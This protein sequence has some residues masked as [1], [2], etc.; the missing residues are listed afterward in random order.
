M[1]IFLD[2][3]DRHAYLRLLG[4]I[5]LRMDWHCL[6]YCLMSNHV[7]LLVETPAPNL[8][9]GMQLLHGRYAM[10]FNERHSAV[11]HLFQGRYG[12]KRVKD[13]VHL[14]TALR[15]LEG[16]PVEAGLVS[17]PEEWPWSSRGTPHRPPWLATERLTELLGL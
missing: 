9:E 8:G 17:R 10:W 5:T 12:A 4:R 7:H 16:N 11:G 2:D 1:A 3:E 13:D 15:Y 14:I 6:M